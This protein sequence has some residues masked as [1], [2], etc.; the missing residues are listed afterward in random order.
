MKRPKSVTRKKKAARLPGREGSEARRERA[1]KLAGRLAESYADARC[2]LEHR[3]PWELLVATILSAQCTDK[4]VNQVTPALFEEFPDAPALAVAPQSRV[5]ALIR[6]TGFFSQKA[7]AIRACAKEVAEKYGGR[8]PDDFD[9]LVG[10]QGVGRKTASV[11]LG[12][13]F[14][15]PAVFV[16]THVRRLS[17]RLGLTR[18]SEPDRIEFDLKALLP[19]A[20]W[21][22][23][24]HRLIHHGRTIC[25]ARAPAC[26]GCPLADLCPR[27]GVTESRSTR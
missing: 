16:D 17:L 21:T 26:D 14:E 11:V 27:L 13:A 1:R 5:E 15:Q 24:C 3:N 25:T 18:D 23:F 12:T 7:R 19:P 20:E 4:M 2:A 10:L 22:M 9:D 8:V 6:R